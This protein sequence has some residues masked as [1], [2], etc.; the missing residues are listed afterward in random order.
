MPKGDN[1]LTTGEAARICNVSTR[2]VQQWFD[3][4]LLKGY[5]LPGSG[6]RRIPKTELKSFMQKYKIPIP[7]DFIV[8]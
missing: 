5:T 7:K 8:S 6:D 2:T 3:K 4:G 1:I